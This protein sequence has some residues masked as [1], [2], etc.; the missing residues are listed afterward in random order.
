MTDFQ[1][2]PW[3][4]WDV[5]RLIPCRMGRGAAPTSF[6][7]VEIIMTNEDHLKIA[8]RKNER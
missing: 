8:Q 6:S 2:N 3:D 5:P 4:Q 1:T 7:Q